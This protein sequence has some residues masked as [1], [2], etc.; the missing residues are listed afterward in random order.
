MKGIFI[1]NPPKPKYTATWNV[2]QV[3]DYLCTLWPVH[4]LSLQYLTFKL[5]ALMALSTAQRV[6]TL[7]Y[8]KL[9]LL[10]NFG[11]Y[12]V[13]TLDNLTKTSKPGQKLQEVRIDK[14]ENEKLCVVNTLKH[15]IKQTQNLRKTDSLFI[16]YKT[17]D[18]VSSSTIARW[19]K[20]VLY[21]SGIDTS[22]FSAHSYRGAA[23]SQAYI[24]GM[25]L[26]DIIK[27]ANWSNAN[28]FFRFYNREVQSKSFSRTVLSSK[29]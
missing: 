27:T 7:H 2:G 13:F 5:T 9:S 15:Y 3:L 4:D 14:F 18:K 12:V 19:L 10:S 8:L 20:N 17:Y 1:S 26:S 21:L 29:D 22:V 25:S 11:D 6:Q 23:T 16:S 24:S 28:T